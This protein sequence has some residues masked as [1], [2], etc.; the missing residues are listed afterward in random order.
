MTKFY[1]LVCLLA[2]TATTTFAA[3]PLPYNID[4]MQGNE[5]WTPYD[6]DGDGKTWGTDITYDGYAVT[7]CNPSGSNDWFVSPE[8]HFV[9]GDKYTVTAQISSYSFLQSAM[10]APVKLMFGDQNYQPETFLCQPQYIVQGAPSTATIEFTATVTGDYPISIVNAVSDNNVPI[11][12]SSFSIE[13]TYS[14][15]PENPDTPTL[16]YSHNFS[17]EGLGDWITYDANGDN[18]TWSV[19]EGFGAYC[20]TYSGTND[21]Y[22]ISPALPF[23]AGI[24]Y[25]AK[26]KLNEFG[27]GGASNNIEVMTGTSK[28]GSGYTSIGALSLVPGEESVVQFQFEES[29]N[30]SIALHETSGMAAAWYV[31]SITIEPA[32]TGETLPPGVKLQKD[33]SDG[34]LQGWTVLDGN[35]DNNKWHFENGAEG[36]SLTMSFAGAQNDWLISPS[37]QL[38]AEKAYIATY[39]IAAS[40]GIEPEIISTAYGA[41]AS[42]EAMTNE[43]ATESINPGEKTTYYHRFTP[44]ADGQYYFGFH[45]TS[46]AFNGT[47]QILDITVKES[48]GITPT[49]PT[50]LTAESDIQAQTV[51]LS[52]KNPSIDT[53]NISITDD[54]NIR[55]TR[56]GETVATVT[57][58]AGETMTYTDRPAPFEGNATYQ[59]YAYCTEG[60]ESE[61]DETTINLDDFQGEQKVLYS[62]GNVYGGDFANW[63]VVNVTGNNNWKYA[64]DNDTWA[65]TYGNPCDDWLISPAIDLSPDRRYVIDVEISSGINFP[66]DIELY[67]GHGVTPEEMDN[68]VQSFTA[69]GNGAIHYTTKQFAVTEAGDYHFGIRATNI[70]TQTT[71]R[72]FTVYYYE[73]NS[74]GP[75][76]TPYTEDFEDALNGWKLPEASSFSIADGKLTS[77]SDGSARN[78]T[79]YTPLVNMKAGYTYEITFDY[80]FEGTESSNFAFCMSAGQSEAE[81][82][83]N[84]LTILKTSDTS[85]RYLFTP[86]SDGTYC[87]AWQLD[88]NETDNCT[89]SIDNLAI[90]INIYTTLPYNEDFES[91]SPNS[92]PTGY[93]GV[94]VAEVEGNMAAS[95]DATASSPWF[96]YDRLRDTYSLTFK[97]ISDTP[98]TITVTNGTETLEAGTTEAADNWTEHTFRI[99]AFE[100]TEAYNIQL[101]F[102]HNGTNAK[103]DD[104]SITMNE[105]PIEASAPANFRAFLSY[106]GDSAD[107]YW[108][109]PSTDTSGE[110]LQNDVT[111]TI[112]CGENQIASVTGAPG[113][114]MQTESAIN[115]SDWVNGIIVFRAVASCNE[116]TGKASTSIIR[117][118]EDRVTYQIHDFDF[119]DDEEWTA[120]DWTLSD[121]AFTASGENKSTLTSPDFQLEE[122]SIYLIRYHLVTSADSPADVTASINGDSQTFKNL[123]LGIDSYTGEYP[124]FE[125]L[126]S[127]I[128]TTGDYN[129]TIEAENIG[130]SVSINA[131]GIYEVREYPAVCELPYENGFD[132]PAWTA[133]N[134]REPNWTI[135]YST[136]PW[137]ISEM[138]ET[139]GISAFSGTRALVAPVAV[140]KNRMDLIY[141]PLFCIKAGKTCKV[142]FE[143]YQPSESGGLGFVYSTDP[144]DYENY[145]EIAD[146]PM[147]AEWKHFETTFTNE[148]TDDANITFGFLAFCGEVANDKIIAIDNFRIAEDSGDGSVESLNTDD[149]VYYSNGNL[150]VPEEILQLAIYDMQGRLVMASDATGTL[151]LSKLNR[152][153]YVVKAKNTDGTVQTI[154]IVK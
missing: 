127:R 104:L 77:T 45:A 103:I 32:S 33:F 126:T 47:I 29:G 23:E 129:F 22:L 120:N 105:R 88:V 125:L 81:I 10:G 31:E 51:M 59:I 106:L 62:C 66:A 89:V 43:I 94:T 17:S 79:I 90:G 146:L 114:Q 44:E 138:G 99:P 86:D 139:S 76:D 91:Y 132:D 78:E 123:Y 54:I 75:V 74:T 19:F 52:W 64:L 112:Y 85:G 71:V 122:G 73:N 111:V 124:Y 150:Y 1:S 141:T 4:F 21:D 16:P 14:Q 57:G 119:S 102:S 101:K 37:M 84:S 69:E 130:E 40:G 145:G 70:A 28:D 34:S 9:E 30:Y 6:L 154:K 15:T 2:L 92:L 12:V 63:T 133:V 49:A 27:M 56:N 117:Q 142:E 68:L 147:S 110:T 24:A 107:L 25:Q 7:R 65:I 39:T 67:T 121:G 128:G 152:G 108:N 93:N 53:E 135:A 143:Y 82:I 13:C 18:T 48:E 149:K 50:E 100:A 151:S 35:N 97:S 41:A 98:I 46:P 60:K 5:G 131:I 80:I 3:E 83:G 140:A 20:S 26:V 42:I 95:I 11:F 61:P 116:T 136:I 36:I 113:A 96:I 137:I 148:G 118:N 134:S 109:N 115:E 58:S 55:I 38:E 144:T 153:I 87:A 72:S 8:F